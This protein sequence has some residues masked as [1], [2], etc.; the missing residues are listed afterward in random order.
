[1]AIDTG[2]VE[3]LKRNNISTKDILFNQVLSHEYSVGLQEFL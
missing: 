1:M 2:A 3:L